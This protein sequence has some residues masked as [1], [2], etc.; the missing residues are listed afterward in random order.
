MNKTIATI[1]TTALVTCLVTNTVRDIQYTTAHGGTDR[2]ISAVLDA[3]D[4]F[5]IYDVEGEKEGDAAAYAII[6][7]LGDEYSSYYSKEEYASMLDEL[8]NSYVGIGVTVA[9]DKEA[10]KVRVVSVA[11][12]Q[13]AEQMGIVSGDYIVAVEGRR[14]NDSELQE[15]VNA[16]KGENRTSVG[17][18]FERNGEEFSL[19]MPR[20]TINVE[21]VSSRVI[22][23]DIGYIKINQFSGKNDSV[24]GAKDTFDYFKES[25]ESL[26]EQNITSLIIDL[27][28]NP[29]GN[30]E[31]VTKIADYLMP[32]GVITYTEDKK[33][34]RSYYESDDEALNLPMA[35]LINR[36]SASASEVLSGALRD[37][38]LATL[39]GEK[40]FGKGVVQS[41]LPLYDGSGVIITSSRYF[42]PS[43]ECIHEKGIEP[44]IPVS[45]DTDTPISKLSYDEDL[46]LKKAVEVLK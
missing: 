7:S 9:A 39:V 46:Q 5:S 23:E 11:E 8:S 38:N 36:A 41:V 42:T 15:L 43:G 13:I 29:G 21:T 12:G 19:T 4:N 24:E 31:I 27:R 33:G 22:E 17:I 16:I 1:I 10:E 28:N 32:N 26:Q 25:I 18:T 2:K 40:T 30:L 44:D 35:V 14:Y 45:L 37:Y 34:E 6:E 3:V 20:E